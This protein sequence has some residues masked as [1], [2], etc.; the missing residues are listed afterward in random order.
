[1]TTNLINAIIIDSE[2][3]SRGL[4]KKYLEK[5]DFINFEAEFSDL[6]EA[7]HYILQH[8]PQLIIV[9]ITD[10]TEIALDMISK[11]LIGNKACKI[12]VTSYEINTNIIIKAMRAG[13]RE[14]LPKPVI[15]REFDEAVTK[16]SNSILG[17]NLENTNC[18]I[19]SVFSNKG[20]IG[21]TSIAVNTALEIAKLTKEKVAI[22]DLNLQLGDVATF[23]DLNSTFDISY[24]VNNLSRIDETFL[25]STLEKYK[26]T[27]L[28]VLA[29]PPHVEQAEEISP[30]DINELLS[31]MR[32][33]FSYIIIDTSSNIDA[34]TIAALDSSDLILLTM[35]VSLPSV[36][37][38]QRSLELFEKLGYDDSKVKLMVNR[39][40]ENEEI[41][42]DEVESVLNRKVYMKIPN[43][44][45][46]LINSINRGIPVGE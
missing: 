42:I 24:V 5:L 7:H 40:L 44:Y 28:Y 21:K 14:F 11:I 4:F 23:M 13:A 45:Y 10:N 41:K 46:T 2:E 1:M 18:K 29:D 20:G 43:N 39:Y 37:N 35:V 26:T 15:E 30:E 19:I 31:V 12:I 22:I 34:K 16:L 8:K 33:T 36:R 32:K 25:L 17:N 27:N 6:I 3:N 9:D 38:A